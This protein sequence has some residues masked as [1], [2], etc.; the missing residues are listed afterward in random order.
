MSLSPEQLSN[1]NDRIGN[2][3]DR[4]LAPLFKRG[5]QLTFIARTPGNDEADVLVTSERDLNDVVAL[6][7]RSLGRAVVGKGTST[8]PRTSGV[9]LPA[10]PRELLQAARD[11]LRVYAMQKPG[12]DDLVTR[13]D[14]M[15]ASGVIPSGGQSNGQ[16]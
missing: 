7:L 6:V 5:T 3:L 4:H 11:N 8:A 16:S 1:L 14:A 10:V 9:A 12:V 13:L 15:L 2:A